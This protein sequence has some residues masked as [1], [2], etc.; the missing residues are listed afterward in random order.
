MNTSPVITVVEFPLPEIEDYLLMN[1]GELI[2]AHNGIEQ[3]RKRGQLSKAEYEQHCSL[4]KAAM[5]VYVLQ[6]KVNEAQEVLNSAVYHAIE[7]TI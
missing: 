6:S 4:H 3:A 1:L 5:Q 7:G 2:N